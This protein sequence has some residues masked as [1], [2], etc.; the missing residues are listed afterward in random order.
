[1]AM[2]GQPL[3]FGDQ[4]VLIFKRSGDKLQ[5]VRRNVHYKAPAGSAVERA[6]KQNYIDSVLLAIPIVSINQSNQAAVVID[7]ADIF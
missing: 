4:W 7:L 2:A 3:N 5:V 1:M 6:V